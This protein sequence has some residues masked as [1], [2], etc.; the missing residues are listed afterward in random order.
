MRE[1]ECGRI[2][3]THGV[4]GELKVDPYCDM[5]ILSKLKTVYI[6]GTAYKLLTCRPH[7]T[8]ALVTLEGITTVEQAQVLKN[9]T[10]LADRD[11]IKL[12]RG[13]YFYSDLYG[14]AVYDFRTRQIVGTLK[15]VK[16]NPASMM[17]I[18]QGEDKEFMIPVVPAF[19]KGV[20]W[21]QK[22]VLVETIE[23]MLPDEN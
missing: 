12:P 7:K 4:R 6:G 18:I 20:D 14:F 10:I 21:E 15:D 11:A 5:P 2:L 3:N 8:F 16:E 23:G 13:K 19:D 9:Q 1:L 17:Y 22:Q